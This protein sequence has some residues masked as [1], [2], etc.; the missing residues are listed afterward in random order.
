MRLNDGYEYREQL[1]PTADGATLLAHLADRYRHSSAKEWA[2]RIEAGQLFLDG[3]RAAADA[4]LRRG[5]ELVWRRPPWEEPP[6]PR[7]FTLIY[8]DG[9]LLAVAKPAGLPTLP[10][11]GFFQSTLLHLVRAQAPDAAPLHRLGRWTSGLVLFARTPQAR[12]ELLRQWSGREVEKRYRALVSG[13]PP[14]ERLIIDTPIGPVPH[15]SLGTIHAASA[16]GKTSLSRVTVLERRADAC[17][18]DVAIETGRPHQIRIHL[19]AA[20]FPLVGDP[21]YR[22]GGLPDPDSRA[23]PGDPGYMLHS[24]ELSFRHPRTGRRMVIRCQPPAPLCRSGEAEVV[25]VSEEG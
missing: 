15:G 20:G 11:A 24:A 14:W 23:L 25:A 2:A 22:P 1:G 16:G 5:G 8:E 17:L 21:L 13:L 18:C 4:L 9:E 3:R 10:G 7:E 6:A 12:G 19:A